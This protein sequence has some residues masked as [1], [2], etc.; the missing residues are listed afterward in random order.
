MNERIIII[1]GMGPQASIELHR[2][3][4]AEAA[5]RGARSGAEFP[6]IMHV[7]LPIDDFISDKGKTVQALHLI[8][9]ALEYFYPYLWRTMR[10]G[11]QYG[12]FATA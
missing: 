4:T 3:I 7:S 11:L 9:G 12:T 1:G 10:A 2:R 5:R 6:E 8:R